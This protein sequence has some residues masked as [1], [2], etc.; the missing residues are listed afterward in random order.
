M[1]ERID[2]DRL[3]RECGPQIER[4]GGC[5][6]PPETYYTFDTKELT[7]Y[8]RAVMEECAKVADRYGSDYFAEKTGAAAIREMMP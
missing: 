6:T 7:A 8:T 3:A 5:G 2:I 1:S 4:L